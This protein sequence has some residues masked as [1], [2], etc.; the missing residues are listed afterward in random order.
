MSLF[1]NI[2]KS[3]IFSVI[4]RVIFQIIYLYQL[5]FG[6][7]LISSN[8]LIV[9]IVP[10]LGFAYFAKSGI[11]AVIIKLKDINSFNGAKALNDIIFILLYIPYIYM[12]GNDLSFI[13]FVLTYFSYTILVYA[14]KCLFYRTKKEYIIYNN[15][16][17]ITLTIFVLFFEQMNFNVNS[18]YIYIMFSLIIFKS[19]FSI[20]INKE[21]FKDILIVQSGNIISSLLSVIHAGRLIGLNLTNYTLGR[22]IGEF[23]FNFFG[24]HISNF[25]HKNGLGETRKKI[26]NFSVILLA[27][28]FLSFIG[29]FLFYNYFYEN[30]GNNLLL[31]FIIFILLFP[32]QIINT[33]LTRQMQKHNFFT[34]GTIIQVISNSTA[35]VAL[36]LFGFNVLNIYLAYYFTFMFGSFCCLFILKFY[37]KKLK[38]S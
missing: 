22:S 28:Y 1:Q 7:D 2:F 16:L 20:K 29:L 17:Y 33:I 11:N 6:L 38:I 15:I 36:F 3:L 21:N 18:N 35:L 37:D 24:Y 4:G 23:P 5:K 34:K 13:S 27:I 30:I 12:V 9:I 8:N 32:L 25:I 14:D 10:A 31:I 26:H 19:V